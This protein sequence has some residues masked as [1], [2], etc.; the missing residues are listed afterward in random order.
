MY[1]L[2]LSCSFFRLF[3]IW[4]ARAPSGNTTFYNEVLSKGITVGM[5]GAERSAGAQGSAGAQDDGL[6]R[7]QG[8]RLRPTKRD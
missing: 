1:I 7:P 3:N 6:D 5:N 2:S 4:G 8:L